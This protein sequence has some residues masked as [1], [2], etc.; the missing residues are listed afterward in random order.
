MT[1]KTGR[2]ALIDE[3]RGLALINMVVYHFLYDI[4]AIY[5]SGP[6]W[7]FSPETNIWQKYICISFI[8]L[9]GISISF[10]KKP[11]I[12]GIIVLGCGAAIS[13]VTYAFMPSMFISF[14]VL[15][16]IG[17]SILLYF[18]F[19]NLFRKI[20]SA[21]G[22]IISVILTIVTW[23]VMN[24][25][26]GIGKYVIDLPEITSRWLS[27]LGFTSPG[28]VSADYFPLMPYFF[29]FTAGV[30]LYDWVKKWPSWTRKTHIRPLEYLGQHTLI[31]YLA[32]Q[33]II[34]GILYLYYNYLAV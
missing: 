25:Y 26:I 12:H 21:I 33:P 1:K 5:N 13:V 30:F 15:H 14:G 31:I 23:N 22:F 8:M 27:P 11:L 2:I 32:H 7:M 10:S 19:Q 34:L 28:F 9:A 24:G 20:N 6:E 17:V 16:L 3:L 29:V 18:I 4:T